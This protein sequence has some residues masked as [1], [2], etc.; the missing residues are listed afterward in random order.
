[1]GKDFREFRN[2]A[3]AMDYTRNMRLAEFSACVQEFHDF[4]GIYYFVLV[5][6]KEE[7]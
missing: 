3:E 5:W 4:D 6:E 1:M 2:Y 7:E